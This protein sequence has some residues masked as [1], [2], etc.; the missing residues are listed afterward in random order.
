M[1]GSMT[2]LSCAVGVSTGCSKSLVVVFS[3]DDRKGYRWQTGSSG[4]V[5]TKWGLGCRGFGSACGV[6]VGILGAHSVV[7]STLGG[8]IGG[9]RLVGGTLGGGRVSSTAT[10]GASTA[11][12]EVVVVHFKNSCNM[13]TSA[14]ACYVQTLA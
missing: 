4:L 8:C 1:A 14:S 5:L 13:V 6:G 3:C 11:I 7:G 10:L 9:K 12:L 2:E